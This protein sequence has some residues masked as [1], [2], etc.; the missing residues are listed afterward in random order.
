[1][2]IDDYLN[3]PCCPPPIKLIPNPVGCLNNVTSNGL[4]WPSEVKTKFHVSIIMLEE[5]WQQKISTF[6]IKV[7]DLNSQN[8]VV[9]RYENAR[10]TF[11]TLQKL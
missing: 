9:W 4:S 7:F 10:N 1:M 8:I 3:S 11:L 6:Y 5:H 2:Q